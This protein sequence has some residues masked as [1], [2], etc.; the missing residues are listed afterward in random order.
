[1]LVNCATQCDTIL[2][3]DTKEQN[4]VVLTREK[5]KDESL[6]LNTQNRKDFYQYRCIVGGDY[7]EDLTLPVINRLDQI[8]KYVERTMGLKNC[9]EIIIVLLIKDV[10]SL[11]SYAVMGRIE[12]SLR[13]AKGKYKLYYCITSNNTYKNLNIKFL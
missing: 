1:M 7:F 2:D 3:G 10:E 12:E 9:E 6:V 8:G 13:K 11:M 4:I 5:P